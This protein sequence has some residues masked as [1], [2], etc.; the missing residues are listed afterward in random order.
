MATEPRETCSGS[1]QLAA[2]L[3]IL[4]DPFEKARKAKKPIPKSG[5]VKVECAVCGR[6]VGTYKRRKGELAGELTVESHWTPRP[7]VAKAT[8]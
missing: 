3:K 6:R 2:G 5:S 8:A 4:L 7:R 1:G